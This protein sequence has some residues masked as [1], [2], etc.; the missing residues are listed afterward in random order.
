MAHI[1]NKPEIDQNK[2]IVVKGHALLQPRVGIN[3][4]VSNKNLFTKIFAR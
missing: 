2:N 4:E 1:L 3:L